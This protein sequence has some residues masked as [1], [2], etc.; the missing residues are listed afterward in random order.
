VVDATLGEA[1]HVR[2][3]VKGGFAE[4]EADRLTVLAEGAL[5]VEAMDAGVV[6][7]ELQTAEADLAAAEDDAGRLAASSAIEQLKT[8][9][10]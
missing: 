5:D 6:S 4:V 8:L 3:F 7:R 10:R 2:V 1:R 9:Q